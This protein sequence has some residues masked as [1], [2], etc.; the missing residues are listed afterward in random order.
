[1][2]EGYNYA[3]ASAADATYFLPNNPDVGDIIRIKVGN[4]AAGKTATVKQDASGD[5]SIDG[6]S[7]VI[8]ESP[9]AALSFCYHVSGSWSIF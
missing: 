6:L 9:Y 2:T 3:T 4:L 1:M 5:N 7:K 8:I